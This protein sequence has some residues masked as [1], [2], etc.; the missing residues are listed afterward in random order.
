MCV[1]RELNKHVWEQF[2]WFQGLLSQTDFKDFI[3]G[4]LFSAKA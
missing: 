1:Y 2:M 3:Y 4:K